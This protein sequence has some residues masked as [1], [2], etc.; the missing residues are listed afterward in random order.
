MDGSMY[1]WMDAK[2][3]G[4]GMLSLF[5]VPVGYTLYVVAFTSFLFLLPFVN[6]TDVS[7][8]VMVTDCHILL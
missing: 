3:A 1:E 6:L 2:H 4:Y 8:S 5:S 7:N